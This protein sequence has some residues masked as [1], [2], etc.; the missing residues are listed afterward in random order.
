[1]KCIDISR[2]KYMLVETISFYVGIFPMGQK[3]I[4]TDHIRLDTRG[5]LTIRYGF[6][7][8]GA[9]DPAIDT[10]NIMTPAMVHDAGYRLIR[11]GFLP[12]YTKKEWDDLMLEMC[13]DRG[14]SALRRSWIHLALDTAANGAAKL[15]PKHD[16]V[17]VLEFP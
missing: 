15:D 7:W 11:M 8:D 10:P 6:M 4:E 1:M 13:K 5:F 14:M 12:R 16:I 17:Q 3:D 2:H 9:S